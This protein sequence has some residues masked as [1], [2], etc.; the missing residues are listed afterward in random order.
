MARYK[1]PTTI[2]LKVGYAHLAIPFTIDRMA[3]LEDLMANSTPVSQGWSGEITATN[4]NDAREVSVQVLAV[5]IPEWVEPTPAPAE[6]ETPNE[7]S[8]EN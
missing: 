1:A 8:E 4:P 5:E 6:T 3:A 2:V 7:T